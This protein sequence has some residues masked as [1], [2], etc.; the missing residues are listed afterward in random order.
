MNE[1]EKVDSEL[2]QALIVKTL[3]T[4][5]AGHRLCLIGGFRYRLLD[6]G[7]R[8][9]MDVDYHWDGDLEAKQ[10][11]VIEALQ[12]RLLPEVQA[13]YGYDGAV[14][15]AKGPDAESISVKTVRVALRPKGTT[16]HVISIPVE[17]TRIECLD[18]PIVRTVKGTVCLTASDADMVESKVISLLNR[19]HV[20]AQDIVDL[21]LFQ[22]AFLPD[23]P[24]RLGVKLSRMKISDAAVDRRLAHLQRYREMHARAIEGVIDEQIDAS[25]AVNLKAAGGG[26]TVLDAVLDRVTGLVRAERETRS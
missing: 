8:R 12:A 5:P 16:G 24:Q 2:I 4:N 17:I 23:S 19:V 1:P 7:A 26:A 13:R 20:Q 9:S 15:A 18:P 14:G 10:Q 11:E 21:F 6:D 22:D 25:V 3:A